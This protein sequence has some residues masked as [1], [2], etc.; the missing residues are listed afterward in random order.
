MGTR[1]ATKVMFLILSNTNYCINNVIAAS[2]TMHFRSVSKL[3]G[4]LLG[5]S[6]AFY[7]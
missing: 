7:Q 3:S 6:V 5:D 1:A 4:M 2:M